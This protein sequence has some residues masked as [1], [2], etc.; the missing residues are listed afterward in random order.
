MT[1]INSNTS[2]Q[3]IKHLKF[4]LYHLIAITTTTTLIENYDNNNSIKHIRTGDW[5]IPHAY[6]QSL[7]TIC[8]FPL[9]PLRIYD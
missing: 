4:L 8:R 2:G 5:H 9:S 7:T 1:H 3:A 6:T